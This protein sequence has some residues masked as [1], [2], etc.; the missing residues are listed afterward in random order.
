LNGRLIE[1][2]FTKHL[3]QGTHKITWEPKNMTGGI[4]FIELSAE[5]FRSTQKLILLK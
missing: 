5:N 2:F 1:E 3:L 4:Y